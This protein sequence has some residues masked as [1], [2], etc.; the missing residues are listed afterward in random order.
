MPFSDFAGNPETIH[1]L[2]EMLARN[3]FPHAVILSGAHG[4]GKYTLA[5][6]LARALNCQ[7]QPATREGSE[8]DPLPD[9]CGHCSNCT[10]IAQAADLD[11]RFAEAVEA[12]EN[13]RDADKKETRL[14]VQTHP[15]VLV[16]PPDPPQMMIK[17]DQ[18]RRVIETIYYRPAEARE[19]IYIFTSSAFMKE[20]ANS[21]LK[22][23]EEP[24][25]FASIFLLTEN[26]GELL[27]TIRSRS[28]TFHLGA[29]P[30][31]EIESRLAE[32]RPDWN[33]RQRALVARLSERAIGRA[34]SFDLESYAAARS[35]ALIMLKGAIDGIAAKA[36]DHSELFKTTEGYRAGAEGREKIDK[37]IRAFYSLLEDVMFL[38]SGAG[39]LVRNTDILGELKKMAESADFAWVQRAAQGLGEV[40]RGLRRNLLRSLSLDAFASALER[41]S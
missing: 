11:A 25:E 7:E 31:G 40:E 14:F 27:P 34:L 28:M 19:R 6:M 16:I 9:F 39:H 13:L 29:L 4:S 33:A 3:R 35:H 8:G 36:G 5:L 30:A 18:V 26:A 20:A 41:V 2:R 37:L 1:R 23:L 22:V 38:Q 12:R 17:V 10:R 24:P 21:L 15:D 32:L